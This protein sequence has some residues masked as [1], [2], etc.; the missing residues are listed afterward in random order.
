MNKPSP[1]TVKYVGYVLQ[2]LLVLV[3]VISLAVKSWALLGVCLGAS[4]VLLVLVC[5]QLLGNRNI[6]NVGLMK[7]N[8]MSFQENA[9]TAQWISQLHYPDFP[10]QGPSTIHNQPLLPPQYVPPMYRQ[11][12][13]EPI[14]QKEPM[15]SSEKTALQIMT[16]TDHVLHQPVLPM[17]EQRIVP[18]S[19]GF[20]PNM[21]QN[22]Y[23]VR[24]PGSKPKVPVHMDFNHPDNPM[25]SL[26]YL[27]KN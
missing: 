12:P 15:T 25:N 21:D 26:A 7:R 16:M 1:D 5:I 10:L 6:T 23:A 22:H 14:E 27:Y 20:D 4:L 18:I 19:Q 11:E 24:V 17:Y 2:L 13:R 9:Q 3:L 8:A